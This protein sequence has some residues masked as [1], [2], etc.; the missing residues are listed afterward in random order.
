MQAI[1]AAFAERM[2][3]WESSTAT[4]V[5]RVDA[6]A[7][8]RLEVD[9][10]RRLAARDLLGGDR[11]AEERRDPA[12]VEH[13]V[14]QLAVR[15]RGEA[16]REAPGHPADGVERTGEPR[17]PAC[18][19][20]EHP[21]DHDPVDL[22][23]RLGEADPV[24]HVARPLGRAHA[25]H[26]PLRAGVP[27]PAALARELLAHVVPDVLGVDEDPVEVEDDAASQRHVP[28]VEVDERAPAGPCSSERTAPT[29]RTWSPSSSSVDRV[30][31]DPADRAR[32]QP[33][34]VVTRRIPSH[35]TSGG[36]L[37]A[38]CWARC[39]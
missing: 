15:G 26:G 34:V 4:H 6:E 24:V 13:G 14:D 18:V 21:L 25:H 29:K 38:K 20:L 19:A 32:E 10:G 1:P 7:A 22:L 12:R 23:R 33:R 36:T 8:R 39:A 17:R 27:A 31:D 11:R 28:P 5:G 9:V 16:E 37:R 2:P 35:W 30:G 3:L